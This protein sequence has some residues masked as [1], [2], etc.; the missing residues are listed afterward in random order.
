MAFFSHS[1]YEKNLELLR[2]RNPLAAHRIELIGENDT[3][4]PCETEKGEA[5]LLKKRYGIVDYY[6]A[7]SGALQEAEEQLPAS[8]LDKAEVIYMFGLG[9]GYLHQALLP[10]LKVNPQNYL[11]FLEDDL[12]VIHSF[13]QTEMA[14]EILTDPQTTLFYFQNYQQDYVNF[15]KLHS[16]FINRPIQFLVLPHYAIRREGE[17]LDLCYNVLHDVNLMSSLHNEYLSGQATFLTNFY[18]NLFSLPQAY[19]ASGLFNQFK[20]VPAIICGAGPSLEKNIDLLKSLT[21]RSLVFAGGSSLNVLNQ[22]GLVPHFGLGVDPNKEQHHRLLTNH[23]FHLP[24]LY[25]SRISHEAFQMMQGPKVYVPGSFNPLANWFER[26][27]DIPAELLDEG[28]N[29]VN[30]C[31]DIAY[32]M[33]CRPIIY[34]G[35]DLAYT[36]V[37][38][39]AA[40]IKTHPLW[41][42]LSQPY[43]TAQQAGVNRVDINGK[44]VKT[45]WDWISEATWLGQFFKRHP[46]ANMINATE[47]G[48]GFPPVPNQA[49]AKV[50]E[51]YLKKS[52]DLTGW[53]HQHIQFNPTNIN[54]GRLFNLLNAMKT[55]LE[56]CLSTCSEIVREKTDELK[57]SQNIPKDFFTSHT[58]I[59]ENLIKSEIAYGNFLEIFDKA[60]YYLQQ[61][62]QMTHAGPAM[63]Y[64]ENLERFRFLASIL[65]QHLD[66][67]GQ[68]VHQFILSPPPIALSQKKPEIYQFSEEYS[69][70]AGRLIMNDSDLGLQIDESFDPAAQ[71]SV[72]RYF[73]NGQLQSEMYYLDDA[74]HGPTRFYNEKGVLLAESWYLK[75]KKEGKCLQFYPSGNLYSLCCYKHGLAHGKQEYFYCNGFSHVSMQYHEGFLDGEVRVSA[76]DGKLLRQLHY[77]NGQRHGEE[78]KWDNAGRLRIACCYEEGSPVGK[79]SEWDA[80]GNL[81]KQVDIHHFPD[82]FD[83]SV[84]R[85]GEQVQTYERGVE[86]SSKMYEDTR[87][88]VEEMENSLA[89]ILS[90]MEPL[91]QKHLENAPDSDNILEEL[92]DIKIAIQEM[93]LM[94]ENLNQTMRDNLMSSE[95]IKK[96]RMENP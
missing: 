68:A 31:T 96:K 84:W 76:I 24:F 6:H 49:L 93:E 32:R 75:G 14:T 88:K 19:L 89:V 63:P 52:Y 55:S 23:T 8:F 46:D 25:R 44:Q 27:L 57:L 82:D 95:E 40:G 56:Q 61:S 43:S 11:V 1:N 2:L 67:M 38:P 48:L 22:A 5:N 45:K 62:H 74:L 30:L 12:E 59:Q 87:K 42:D 80:Q 83:L 90:Q 78:K 64:F 9:L 36:E 69:Y 18:H 81:L 13:L 37:Q 70:H 20:D 92:A 35:M 4:I 65:K 41:I 16:S 85:E 72:K 15:C 7:N 29:V 26:Q 3:L 60:Y 10:W 53:V 71:N 79:A 54:Q 91:I 50:A 33:G 17:A 39:Y 86:N 21:D 51:N 28:H 73:E 94:K 47:G 34:V 66:L 58:I 77:R